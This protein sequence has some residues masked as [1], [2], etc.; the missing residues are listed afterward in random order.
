MI[1]QIEFEQ[2][3]A[4][5]FRKLDPQTQRRIRDY[6]KNRVLA[7]DDPRSKGKAL[8]GSMHV[9]WRYRIGNYRV[10]CDIRDSELLILI[11]RVAHRRE[12]YD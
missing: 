1:W 7:V 12:V 4:R 2:A 11:V 9:L 6:L 10:V 8:K 5:E 3:A